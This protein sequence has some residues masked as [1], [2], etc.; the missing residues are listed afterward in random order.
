MKQLSLKPIFDLIN[1][2]ESTTRDGMNGAETKYANVT[3]EYS[4]GCS[5]STSTKGTRA[6]SSPSQTTTS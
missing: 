6:F 5:G 1:Q 3:T 2:G 4:M